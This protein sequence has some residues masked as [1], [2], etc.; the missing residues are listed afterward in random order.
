MPNPPCFER[1][2]G[3]TQY[4]GKSSRDIMDTICSQ[5]YGQLAAT[6]CT[7]VLLK[8]HGCCGRRNL[9]ISEE[10]KTQVWVRG[11]LSDGPLAGHKLSAGLESLGGSARS[12]CGLQAVWPCGR[13]LSFAIQLFDNQY[14]WAA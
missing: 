4:D 9:K 3:T 2:H 12:A 14:G 11:N 8:A 13:S 6:G 1:Y 10:K 7:G 5:V